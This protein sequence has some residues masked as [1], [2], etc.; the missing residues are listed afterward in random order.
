MPI[1]GY[2]SWERPFTVPQVALLVIA[3]AIPCVS[4]A[5]VVA[6][7]F[8]LLPHDP[9]DFGLFAGDG[10]LITA[11]LNVTV[12]AVVFGISRARTSPPRFLGWLQIAGLLS[13]IYL[14]VLVVLAG[15]FARLGG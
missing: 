12:L 2:A 10:M 9:L 6:S 15:W 5:L 4:G 7:V 8:M 13:G 1:G 14:A 11:A 3:L